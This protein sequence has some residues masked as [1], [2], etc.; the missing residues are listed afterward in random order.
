[1]A[2]WRGS[3]PRRRAA[4]PLLVS[5]WLVRRWLLTGPVREP[6]PSDA[7]AVREGASEISR[8]LHQGRPPPPLRAPV[9]A[10]ERRVLD[11]ADEPEAVGIVAADAEAHF[12]GADVLVLQQAPDV[13]FHLASQIRVLGPEGIGE[14]VDPVALAFP[15]PHREK[16]RPHPATDWLRRHDSHWLPPEAS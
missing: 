16:S 7:E 6:L 3:A 13:L 9:L 15:L 11:L 10:V 2:R 4:I 8:R 1:M 5:E 14:D 12:D